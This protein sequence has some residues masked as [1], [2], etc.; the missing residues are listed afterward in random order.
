[1]ALEDRGKVGSSHITYGSIGDERRDL[2]NV[3]SQLVASLLATSH[4]SK[5]ERPQDDGPIPEEQPELL[6]SR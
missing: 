4:L 2:V 6:R 3:S 1:M 5:F